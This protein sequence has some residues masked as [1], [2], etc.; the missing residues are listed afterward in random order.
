MSPTRRTSPSPPLDRQ[1]LHLL[2]ANGAV[3]ARGRL[4]MVLFGIVGAECPAVS[5]A[6]TTVRLYSL[7]RPSSNTSSASSPLQ[8][9]LSETAAGISLLPLAGSFVEVVPLETDIGRIL[10]VPVSDRPTTR[11]SRNHQEIHGEFCFLLPT[12]Q[13]PKLF[14]LIEYNNLAK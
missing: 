4:E 6:K 13:S 2:D 5:E 11:A 3:S 7:A 14:N 8:S 10:G 1:C 12:G 9:K